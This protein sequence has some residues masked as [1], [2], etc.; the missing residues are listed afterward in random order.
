[1][2]N[3]ER[4][5]LYGGGGHRWRNACVALFTKTLHTGQEVEFNSSVVSRVATLS[6]GEGEYALF[7]AANVCSLGSHEG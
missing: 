4:G 5:E 7:C 3:L 2:W 6:V 1:M